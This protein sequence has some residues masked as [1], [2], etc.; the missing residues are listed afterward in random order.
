M[1]GGGFQETERTPK[2]LSPFQHGKKPDQLLSSNLKTVKIWIL[3]IERQ[4]GNPEMSEKQGVDMGGGV[5]GVG[6]LDCR[7][8]LIPFEAKLHP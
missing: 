5:T 3:F 8:K 7:S 1:A 4:N 6:G 2:Y